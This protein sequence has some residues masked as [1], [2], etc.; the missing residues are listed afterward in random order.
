MMVRET[1][2]WVIIKLS[3][4]GE[5]QCVDWEKGF[6][7]RGKSRCTKKLGIFKKANVAEESS[8]KEN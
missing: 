6:M 4:N 7:G 3:I 5:I 2:S 8:K 1:L